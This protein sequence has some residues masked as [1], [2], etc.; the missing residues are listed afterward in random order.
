MSN[1]DKI[2]LPIF[3]SLSNELNNLIDS[4][5]VSWGSNGQISLTTIKGKEDD[6]LIGTGSLTHDWNNSYITQNGNP[7]LI[8]TKKESPLSEKDLRDIHNFSIVDLL[9]LITAYNETLE[10]YRE[11][12]IDN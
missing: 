1:F 6:Y 11:T 2:D 8:V 12:I 3:E 4:K 9:S 10:F 5:K 7:T